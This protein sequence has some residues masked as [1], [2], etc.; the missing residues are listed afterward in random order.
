[1]K[2]KRIVLR[3]YSEGQLPSGALSA[4]GAARRTALKAAL[5]EVALVI[6]PGTLFCRARSNVRT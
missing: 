6:Y 2:I 3:R 5:A 4:F 1:M